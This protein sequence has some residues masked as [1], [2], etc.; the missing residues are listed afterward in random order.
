MWAIRNYV[1]S[2]RSQVFAKIH[3][4]VKAT[5]NF[6]QRCRNFLQFMEFAANEL[7]G[8]ED[9]DD[10]VRLADGIMNQFEYTN[11]AFKIL[12][13]D[14]RLMDLDLQENSQIQSQTNQYSVLISVFFIGALL[15]AL[16][17]HVRNKNSKAHEHLPMI[18]PEVR[19]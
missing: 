4:N 9:D 2:F 12:N 19:V 3:L 14:Y 13:K 11:Q 17:F 7:D 15:G 5:T 10:M 1:N 18:N 8:W 16:A 6:L